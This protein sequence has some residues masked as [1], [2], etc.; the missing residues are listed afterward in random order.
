MIRRDLTRNE[1]SKKVFSLECVRAGQAKQQ[2]LIHR[3]NRENTFND[4][5]FAENFLSTR[6]TSRYHRFALLELFDDASE[7][8]RREKFIFGI[9]RR[10]STACFRC[11][12][13]SRMY[14]RRRGHIIRFQHNIV[15]MALVWQVLTSHNFV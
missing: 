9:S 11:V 5:V 8:T 15:C 3:H 4:A 10:S 7:K 12:S 6:M 13:S 14:N 2:I 1:A